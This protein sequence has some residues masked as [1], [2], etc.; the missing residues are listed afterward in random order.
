[1]NKNNVGTIR[2]FTLGLLTAMLLGCGISG[3][4]GP[5][6]SA[7]N[8]DKQTP[9]D[10]QAVLGPIIGAA[11]TIRD[12][13]DPDAVACTTTTIDD[14]DLANAGTIRF[15]QP[16]I[17]SDRLY[18]VT[19]TGGNDVDYNDDGIRDTQATPNTGEFR[20]LLSG[21]Q[22]LQHNWKTNALTEAA[23]QAVQYALQQDATNIAAR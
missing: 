10:G 13:E 7:D 2:T 3:T 23:Y 11:V 12:I 16:C 20:A 1:M 15:E 5:S 6:R 22:L 8:T 17:F 4:G 9:Q 19:I 14:S 18:L 21:A